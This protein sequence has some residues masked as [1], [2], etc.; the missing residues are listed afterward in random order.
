MATITA[1]PTAIEGHG[2]D[3]IQVLWETLTETNA[4]GS[5]L[6]TPG[7]SDKSVHVVGNFG[8]G[9]TC[10]IQG[11][12][13]GT[14]W[15]TLTDPQGNALSFTSTGLEMIAENPLYI[16]PFISAGTGVDLDV[17][18]VAKRVR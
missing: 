2:Q 8:I 11:S 12:N 10:V 17:Y 18:L 15:V 13:D 14:N 5:L 9:G 1:V 3:T 16:R 7:R 4:D 6:K